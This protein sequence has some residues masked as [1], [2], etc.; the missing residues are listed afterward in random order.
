MSDRRYYFTSEQRYNTPG[1]LDNDCAEDGLLYPSRDSNNDNEDDND[2]DNGANADNEPDADKDDDSEFLQDVPYSSSSIDRS[3]VGSIPWADDAIKKNLLDW[4]RVERMLSG[5]EELPEKEPELRHEIADWQHKF[6][7]LV[8]R[9]VGM[10]SLRHQ[11]FDS[12]TRRDDESVDIDSISNLSLNSLDDD[13][14]ED[15]EDDG[16]LTPTAEPQKQ[17]QQPRSYLR[18]THN[19]VDLLDRDLRVTSVSV[20]LLKR[21]RSQQQQQHHQPQQLPQKLSS[22]TPQSARLRMPPIL[23]VLDTNRRFRGLLNNR[24]FVQLTQVQQQQQQQQQQAKS[25]ALTHASSAERRQYQYHHAGNRSAW[26]MPMAASRFFSNNKNAIVLPA[27]NLSRHRDYGR[28]TAA[29]TTATSS[30]SNSSGGGGHNSHS[31]SNSSSRTLHPF[32]LPTNS[33]NTPSTGR[34]ISAAVHHPRSEFA[35]NSAFYIPYSASKFKAFK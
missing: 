31:N 22:A 16:F 34:S 26:H 8:G 4:E 3:S 14:D 29:T 7:M 21:Q 24:S 23:N 11:S 25:A 18:P 12:Q 15:I 33:S 13:D 20:K 19:L 35:S 32:A 10:R 27:L 6:P 9:K 28:A 30:Q 1:A 2:N 5:E 17:H